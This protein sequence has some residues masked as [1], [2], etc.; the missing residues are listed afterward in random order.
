VFTA[1]KPN[2]DGADMHIV[3]SA[4]ELAAA[5]AAGGASLALWTA[6]RF[7]RLAPRSPRGTAIAFAAALILPSVTLPLFVPVGHLV[8]AVGAIFLVALPTL[9]YMFLAAAWLMQWLA[10]MLAPL[11]R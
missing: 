9:V 3:I 7:P 11:R 4:G 10:R 6:V 2:A 8:S 5:L 1:V